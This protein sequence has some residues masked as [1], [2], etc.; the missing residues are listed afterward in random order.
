MWCNVKAILKLL[1]LSM[2]FFCKKKVVNLHL[3][4]DFYNI[5]KLKQLDLYLLCQFLLV[6]LI[7]QIQYLIYINLT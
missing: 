1:K 4:F 6:Y 3:C 5:Q 7:W 2:F